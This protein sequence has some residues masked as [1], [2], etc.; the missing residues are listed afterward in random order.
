LA[1]GHEGKFVLVRGGSLV[2]IWNTFAELLDATETL[3]DVRNESLVQR[4]LGTVPDEAVLSRY[5]GRW[6][7]RLVQ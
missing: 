6:P 1:D 2:G 3:V 5:S 4:V 7:T